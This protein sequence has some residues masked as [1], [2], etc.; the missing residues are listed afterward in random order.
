MKPLDQIQVLSLAINLP[1]PVAV[2]RLREL[3][4]AVVKIEPPGG[5]PL[6]HAR[7]DWY[8]ELHAGVELLRLNLRD[9]DARRVLHERL[10]R[11]DLLVTA[12]RPSALR[13]LGLGWAEL[14]ARWPAL[15]HVAL[16]GHPAPDE[17]RPGHDLNFQAGV[18]LV[19]PPHL[20]CTCVADLAG[21]QELVSACL[22]VLLA[23]QRGQGS[24]YAEVSLARAAATFAGPLRRGL[25]APG[26]ILGGGFPGYGLYPAQEGW[27]AVAVLEPH[28]GQKLRE[29]LGLA[30]LSREGLEGALRART[31]EE[32]ERWAAERDLPLTAVRGP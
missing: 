30:G 14:H 3:G 32:W 13:R 28:F 31:A 19:V 22:A 5:D 16:V 17:E 20:P 24:Q 27:V 2:S 23:R 7:P 4:A 11:A 25:T 18:G 26:G 15:C 8:A 1:G 12:N 21:S 29:E 9:A 10:G 6:H